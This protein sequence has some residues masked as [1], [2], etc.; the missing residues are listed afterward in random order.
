M[1]ALE[2]DQSIQSSPSPTTW[3][4]PSPGTAVTAVPPQP[5]PLAM[6]V[7]APVPVWMI[8][9]QSMKS[10]SSPASA[11]SPSPLSVG[12]CEDAVH[13]GRCGRARRVAQRVHVP[14][15][16]DEVTTGCARRDDVVAVPTEQIGEPDVTALPSSTSSPSQPLTF[17]SAG[18]PRTSPTRTVQIERRVRED[19]GV[20]LVTVEVE[21]QLVVGAC[22]QVDVPRDRGVERIARS[23]VDHELLAQA[24]LA[25]DDDRH[26]VRVRRAATRQPVEQ[27]RSWSCQPG[28]RP[29]RPSPPSTTTPCRRRS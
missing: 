13:D 29:P 18:E 7:S 24:H 2:L 27:D 4:S 10:P 8:S 17:H 19:D 9:K 25:E 11:L 23:L 1:P 15:A 6:I 26:G 20:V 16:A 5:S 28:R 3:S 12:P 22:A 14:I 21:R